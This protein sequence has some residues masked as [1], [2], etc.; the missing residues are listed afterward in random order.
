V[1]KPPKLLPGDT[2]VTISLSWGGA[3]K[4]PHRYLAGKRQ[5]QEVFGVNVVESRH[6]LKDQDWLARNP[7]ARAEDLMEAFANP[8]YKAIIS[9]IGGEDFI[10]CQ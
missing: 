5:L 9:N 4:F 2:V 10:P 7:Q 3:Q 1:I 8:I 6:A